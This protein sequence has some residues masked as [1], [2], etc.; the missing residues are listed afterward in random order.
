LREGIE[1][2]MITNINNAAGSSIAQSELPVM[3][4]YVAA[5][6]F[7][8][9]GS[10]ASGSQVLFNHIPGGANV[11]YMDGHVKFVVY[12]SAKFPSH[13]SVARTLGMT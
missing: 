5:D 4:D 12:P 6:I 13:I 10:G 2:F 1:R 9:V 3:W 8:E 7:A 11:L